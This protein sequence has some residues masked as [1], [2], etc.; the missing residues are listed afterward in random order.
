MVVSVNIT[1]WFSEI[2][3]YIVWYIC[4][5]TTEKCAASTVLSR[6]LGQYTSMNIDEH[7]PS[8]IG[9]TPH[10]NLPEHKLLTWCLVMC[11][12]VPSHCFV[13]RT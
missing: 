2:V 3:C 5:N 12:V 4:T 1:L 8:D 10:D 11:F 9:H 7:I 13:S 6:G